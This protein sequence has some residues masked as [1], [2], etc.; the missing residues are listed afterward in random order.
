MRFSVSVERARRLAFGRQEVWFSFRFES[1]G[2]DDS[3]KFC[4]V[5]VWESGSMGVQES[6]DREFFL[7]VAW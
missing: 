6:L 7:S 2:V 3:N 4:E 1:S 5:Y